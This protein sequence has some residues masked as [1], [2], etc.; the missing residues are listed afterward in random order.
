MQIPHLNHKQVLSGVIVFLAG[1]LVVFISRYSR[2]HNRSAIPVETIKTVYIWNKTDLE[3]LDQA[4]ERA[5][6]TFNKKE[7]H[8]VARMLGWTSIQPGRYQF[9]KSQSYPE[10][11]KRFAYGI[12]TPIRLTI[13]PG[14]SEERF[15][16][17]VSSQF[18]FDGNQFWD[19]M[20]DTTALAALGI[21]P[22]DMI[23]HMLPDTY[24]F[25]WTETPK[26]VLQKILEAFNDKAVDPYR[27]QYKKVGKSVDQILTIAS[28]VE[29]EAGNN[30]EKPTIAGLYWNRLKKGW[31][32]QADPTINYAKGVRGRLLYDD[33]YTKS[34]YNTY[35]HRGL[36]PGPIT[37]PSLSSI[38]AALFPDDNDYMFMVATPEGVHVFS[39]TFAQHKR[40]SAEWRKWL[41][42]QY[43]I[44]RE[45]E[46]ARADSLSKLHTAN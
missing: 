17:R 26:Q 27:Q 34:P 37:N 41:R 15:A 42:K 38:K 46:Q 44:K 21:N 19:L 10:L 9:N 20:H 4:L 33:Y 40:R 22:T 29:W 12:Q 39:K 45:R 11:V 23:G 25:Y 36:P 32:L 31:R 6:V 30:E 24:Q 1:F 28:I 8:W 3:G 16:R 43:R 14:Q 5:D 2:I 18:R 7:L 13:L 35:L